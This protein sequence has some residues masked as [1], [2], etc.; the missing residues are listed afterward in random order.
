MKE[1]KMKSCKTTNGFN[2]SR[3]D[4]CCAF[5]FFKGEK[6]F[7]FIKIHSNYCILSTQIKTVFQT[8]FAIRIKI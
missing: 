7:L 6:F 2:N 5:Q 3:C 8:K 4:Q 1:M